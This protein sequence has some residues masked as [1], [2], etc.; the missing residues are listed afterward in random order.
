MLLGT[1]NVSEFTYAGDTQGALTKRR[2]LFLTVLSLWVATYL[3]HLSGVEHVRYLSLVEHNHYSDIVI[4]L[5]TPTLFLQY[6]GYFAAHWLGLD[7]SQSAYVGYVSWFLFTAV[8]TTVYLAMMLALIAAHLPAVTRLSAQLIRR[9]LLKMCGLLLV[10]NISS[11][12]YLCSKRGAIDYV[13]D[14]VVFGVISSIV[15]VVTCVLSYKW[16]LDHE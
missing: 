12:I 4:I 13:R 3:P 6:P 7:R 8:N 11:T 9:W 16:G 2:I 1:D 15:G 5:A 14:G 10:I